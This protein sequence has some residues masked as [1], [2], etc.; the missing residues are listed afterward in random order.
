MTDSI[1]DGVESLPL[2]EKITN[3]HS[4]L[5]VFVVLFTVDLCLLLATGTNLMT[6]PWQSVQSNM[7]HGKIALLFG[8]ALFCYVVIVPVING[9]L[10]QLAIAL[11][12]HVF[13]RIA[14]IFK[15]SD[16]DQENHEYRKSINDRENVPTWALKRWA[17]ENNDPFAYELTKENTAAHQRHVRRS[18]AI[19]HAS[20]ALML[21]LFV[22]S[23]T[24][25]SVW[26]EIAK[27][28][29]QHVTGEL[30]WVCMGALVLSIFI[31]CVSWWFSRNL[32]VDASKVFYPKAA[33]ERYET[34]KKNRAS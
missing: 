13:R 18:F 6:Y 1:K 10:W 14:D 28:I 29:N 22:E 17:A 8:A 12:W 19:N 30:R 20:A 25:N 34:S 11:E 7:H 23:E 24:H 33:I 4:T 26:F 2:I 9:I 27:L 16:K 3:L 5:L 15:S 21:L 32:G 31:P